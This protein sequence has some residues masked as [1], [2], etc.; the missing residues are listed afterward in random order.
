MADLAKASLTIEFSFDGADGHNLILEV[1]AEDNNG[2]TTFTP[3]DNVYFRLYQVGDFNYNIGT[4]SGSVSL[5]R[6]DLLSDEEDDLIFTP[7][8]R[9][10]NTKKPVHSVTNIYWYGNSLGSLSHT[11]TSFSVSQDGY[12]V[13][14]IKYKSLYKEYLLSN[15]CSFIPADIGKFTVLVYAEE[16]IGG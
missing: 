15:A 14:N 12:G 6:S 1:V 11:G 16:I 8:E 3:G 4:T 9:T 10:N 13:A 7:S 5:S 2:K